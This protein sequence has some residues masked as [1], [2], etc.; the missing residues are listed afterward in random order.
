MKFHKDNGFTIIEIVITLTLVA[1][2]VAMAAPGFRSIV[3]NNQMT[4]QA[5]ELVASL[6]MAR[7]EAVKRGTN[8]SVCASIDS[9]ACNGSTNWDTGWIVFTDNQVAGTVDGGDSIIQTRGKTRKGITLVVSGMTFIRYQP[10][11]FVAS[12]CADCFNNLAR[13]PSVKTGFARQMTG[14][15]LHLLPLSEAHA[16]SGDNG[17]GSGHMGSEG[18]GNSEHGGVSPAG[19]TP[20]GGTAS[21]VNNTS[22]PGTSSIAI[23]KICDGNRTGETGRAVTVSR[24][25]RVTISDITCD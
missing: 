11:G 12:N 8:V 14:A 3:N 15:L 24:V 9:A 25:G 22:I 4:T 5:N 23:F 21:V 17:L 7:S 18:S 2:L 1:I 16:S 6:M 19:G 20:A 10:S 13:I